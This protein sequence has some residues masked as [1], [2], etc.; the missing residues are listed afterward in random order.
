MSTR[1]IAL[2]LRPDAA[3]RAALARLRER[4]NAACDDIS[5]VA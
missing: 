1:T 5:G 3:E 4:F 2:T